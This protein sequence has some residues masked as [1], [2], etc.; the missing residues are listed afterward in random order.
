MRHPRHLLAGLALAVGLFGCADDAPTRSSLLP[1][2]NSDAPAVD[3]PVADAPSDTP[4]DSDAPV[5]GTTDPVGGVEDPLGIPG[6]SLD[7]NFDALVG[8]EPG[9]VGSPYTA[10]SFPLNRLQ[11]VLPPDA[12][13][14]LT[15]P[16][17]VRRDN[18][19]YLSNNDLVF[20]VVI[21]G[22]AR[23]YP[24]NIGWWHEIV[25]DEVGGHPV[26]ITFCPLTGTGLVFDGVKPGGGRRELG[27]SGLL[28]NTNLVMF[29]RDNESLFPQIYAA[30]INGLDKGEAL[31]L[32]PVVE[33]T[34]RA[35]KQLY[36]QTLVLANGTYNQSRYEQYPYSDYRTNDSYFLFTIRPSL[37]ANENNYSLQF[38]AKDRVLGLRIG[39]QARAYA[40]ENMGNQSVINDV[41][42]EHEVLVVYDSQNRMTIP[43]SR[44]VDDQVLSFDIV[45]GGSFPF[46]L[47]DFETETLWDIKGHAIEGELAGQ[48]LTQLPAHNSMWFAWV[49]FWPNTDIWQP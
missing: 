10:A 7:L 9:F 25:N 32:L 49:T 26:S 20:G 18:V 16:S 31:S 21:N 17:M 42:G 48:Q 24:H 3:A 5:G 27:V 40:F 45:H 15:D 33:T 22:E 28:Y 43:Y 35:W 47:R 11:S 44:R 37:S 41:L 6:G 19:D 38:P 34:W 8:T 13:P 23:A 12:I 36:P 39:A 2:S 30:G 29:D 14:A 46:S 4:T 1:D